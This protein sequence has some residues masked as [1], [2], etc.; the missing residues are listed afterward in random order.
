MAQNLF[1]STF[2]VITK[3]T[4]LKNNVY[5]YTGIFLRVLR[6]GITIHI[7]NSINHFSCSRILFEVFRCIDIIL[8]QTSKSHEL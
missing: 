6:F 8:F 3:T 2:Q 4:F 5:T 7:F 1:F